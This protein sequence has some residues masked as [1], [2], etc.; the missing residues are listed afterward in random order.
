ML[1]LLGEAERRVG[2][3]AAARGAHEAARRALARQL[4]EEHPFLVRNAALRNG[5]KQ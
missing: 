4:S 1:D 5:A 3:A 2:E